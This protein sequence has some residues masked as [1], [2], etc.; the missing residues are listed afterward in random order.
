M[1]LF[2]SVAAI[3]KKTE[4]REETE[5]KAV[6]L[7]R[8]DFLKCVNLLETGN[9]PELGAVATAISVRMILLTL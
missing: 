4:I 7:A 3:P 8:E 9:V 6:E 2:I 1:R 5:L